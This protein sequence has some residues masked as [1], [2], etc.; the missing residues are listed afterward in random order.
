MKAVLIPAAV[1]IVL[2][3]G[4]AHAPGEACPGQYVVRTFHLPEGS[5]KRTFAFHVRAQ[6]LRRV[7][8]NTDIVRPVYADGAEL[9]VTGNAA[10]SVRATEGRMFIGASTR[11]W[12]RFAMGIGCQHAGDVDV[13]TDAFEH[14]APSGSV[15]RGTIRKTTEAPAVVR[16]RFVFAPS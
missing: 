9:T 3:G 16:F 1:L 13:C 14:C 11:P 4:A 12:Q 2:V 8:A 10:V 6:S 5:S 15:W 7:N